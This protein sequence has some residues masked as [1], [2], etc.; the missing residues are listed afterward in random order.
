MAALI[1][2]TV[3]LALVAAAAM[4]VGYALYE[5]SRTFTGYYVGGEKGFI[6]TIGGF[7]IVIAIPVGLLSRALIR[8]RRNPSDTSN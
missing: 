8:R 4:S 7:L 3:G 6:W 2:K 5:I 1:L